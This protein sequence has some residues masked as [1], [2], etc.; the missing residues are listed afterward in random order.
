MTEPVLKEAM[1]R[2]A[3]R[4]QALIGDGSVHAE[5]DLRPVVSDL[6]MD[7]SQVKAQ[8]HQF[9]DV[10]VAIWAANPFQPLCCLVTDQLAQAFATG[11]LHERIRAERERAG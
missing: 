2:M 1:D 7:V 6:D 9:A 5:R 10:L 3:D 8:M 4:I 11:I